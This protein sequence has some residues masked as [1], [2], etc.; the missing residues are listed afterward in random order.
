MADDL[1]RYPITVIHAPS[2]SARVV[3]GF[4]ASS[5]VVGVIDPTSVIRPRS[6]RAC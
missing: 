5:A 1:R 2:V 4:G 6:C 3:E